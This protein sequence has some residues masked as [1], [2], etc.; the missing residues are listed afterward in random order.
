[1]ASSPRKKEAQR[2]IKRIVTKKYTLGKYRNWS[3][4]KYANIKAGR[5]PTHATAM[6]RRMKMFP[7]TINQPLYR[8]ISGYAIKNI[9]LGNKQLNNSFASFSV[10]FNQARRFAA[11]GGFIM[12]LPPGRYPAIN[13]RTFGGSN[14]LEKEVTLA[15]GFYV[16]NKNK[17]LYTKNR[18][19]MIPVKYTPYGNYRPA[20]KNY[21]P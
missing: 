4:V 20:P 16:L 8:G 1:M 10:N 17:A 18:Y 13:S 5:A 2:T 7:V 19:N 21:K 11:G 15:P 6:L 14:G 12:I 9:L 3:E